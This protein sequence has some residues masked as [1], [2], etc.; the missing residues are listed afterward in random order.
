MGK[1]LEA[2]RCIGVAEAA[3]PSPEVARSDLGI[4][5]GQRSRRQTDDARRQIAHFVFN[6]FRR[7][8]GL[9]TTTLR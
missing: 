6:R 5:R 8:L 1:L 7:R 9:V 3:V 4:Q 2:G